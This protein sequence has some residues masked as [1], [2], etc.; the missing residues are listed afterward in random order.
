MVRYCQSCGRSA[1]NDAV[2]CPYCGVH[3]DY[4]RSQIIPEQPEQKKKDNTWIIIVVALIVILF[5]VIIAIAAT[6]YVYVS[7]QLEPSD[8]FEKTPEIY[9]VK[10]DITNTLTVVSV[11][12][13][14]LRWGDIEISVSSGGTFNTEG[15]S[16]DSTIKS[17]DQLTNCDGTITIRYIKTNTLLGTWDFT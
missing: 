3:I 14:N 16:A 2:V 5:L 13:D 12:P 8:D 17:G 7:G 15:L 6:V 1:P 4:S 11:S 9:F 10:N